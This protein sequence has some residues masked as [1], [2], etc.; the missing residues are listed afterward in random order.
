MHMQL[1]PYLA[2]LDKD[3]VKVVLRL[4]KSSTFAATPGLLAA[5]ASSHHERK[6]PQGLLKVSEGID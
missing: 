1:S 6:T 4:L 5:L 2:P 3:L